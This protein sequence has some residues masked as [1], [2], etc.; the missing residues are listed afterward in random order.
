MK[1]FLDELE[2]HRE[3]FLRDATPVRLGNLASTLGHI[4]TL[5]PQSL[6][7]RGVKKMVDEAAWFVEWAVPEMSDVEEQAELVDL[8]RQLSKWRNHWEEISGDETARLQV[9]RVAA[10][11]SSRVLE[12]SGLL[13]KEPTRL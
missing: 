13:E 11:W 12:I 3:R 5:V 7:T 9:A 1:D 8:Q 6:H 2:L 10:R 4:A